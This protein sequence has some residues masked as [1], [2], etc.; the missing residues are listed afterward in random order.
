[1]AGGGVCVGG[2][3]KELELQP[4]KNQNRRTLA[5]TWVGG[6]QRKW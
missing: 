2:D 6:E 1:V 3:C 5:S 4:F